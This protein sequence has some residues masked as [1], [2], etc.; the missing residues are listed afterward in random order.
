V[1]TEVFENL[2]K[3][4]AKLRKHVAYRVDRLL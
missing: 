2:L 1:S 4:V 3:F